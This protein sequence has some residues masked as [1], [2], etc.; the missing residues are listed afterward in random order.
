MKPTFTLFTALLLGP[1]AALD[2]A[3]LR[4]PSIFS[5]HMVLQCSKAVPV[6]GWGDAGE[7][8]VVEF[9]G[10]TKSTTA[11]A[12]G[13]WTVNLDAL[14]A[15]A[16]SREMVVRSPNRSHSVKIADV[17]VGEVWVGGGQS[18]MEFDM[19]AIPGVAAE[20][21]APTNPTLR[22]FHVLKNPSSRNPAD[23]VQG[24]WTFARPGTTEDFIAAGYYFAKQ[25]QRELKTPVGLI[26]VC[27]GGSKVEPWIS[28]DSLARVPELATAAKN[29][30]A[31]SERN[32]SA[33]LEWLK[34]TKREDRPAADVESFT[35]GPA[36]KENGWVTVR[37]N[38][39]SSDPTLPRLGAF[40]FRK[41]VALTARQTGAV[42]MLQF[43]PSAQF[44]QVYWNGTLIGA[45]DVDS[46]TGLT[47]VRHYLI[48]PALLKEGVNHLAVRIFAP[49]EQPGF[50][51]PPSVGS[52]KIPD[53][54]MAKAEYALP[55]LEPAAKQAVPPLTGQHV[56]PARLFHGMVHPILPY[57]IRGVLWYQGE[58]NTGNASLY[59]TTFPL[60]IRDWR[61]HWKQGDFP[62]YFCQLANYRPKTEQPGE[63]IWADL[64][65]AQAKTLSVP[66]TGMAVL[67]DT[68]ESEDIHP[69]SKQVAGE[70]L[71]RIALA[72]TYGLDVS[73]S[74][75]VYA[76]MRVESSAIRLFF[77]HLGGGLVAKELPATYDV[78]CKAGKTAPLARNSPHSQLE[79]FAIC[80]T[81][82][83][84]IWADARID[85][86]TVLVSSGR[87]ATP[88]A[89]RYGWSDN[90]T[91]NLYNAADLPASPFRT[92]DFPTAAA[93]PRPPLMPTATAT[94]ATISKP[95][96]LF[97]LADD[98]G[99]G[100]LRCHGNAKLATPSLDRLRTQSVELEHFHVS[101]IC[102]P[103][104]S[105]LLTGRHHARL[106]V[107][108]TS[109]SLEVMHGD[110]TTLAEA[111][112][113]AG[114]VAGCFGKWHN[115]SNHPSTARGQGFDEFFGFSGGFFPNYF[116]AQLEH[117]GVSTPTRGFITDVLA[118]AAMSF[119]DQNRARPFFCYVPFNACHSP[120]QAPQDLFEKYR[121]LG[122]EPKDAAVY[123]MIEN[124]DRN[125]GRL[126]QKLDQTGL[127]ANTIVLFTTDNGPNTAR[128][129][130]GMRGGKGSVFEGG[131]RVPC[132]IR[133]PDKLKSG[134]RVP[135]ITQHVDILPTLL[136]LAAVPLPKRQPLDGVS[137]VPLLK[138]N[139]SSWPQRT[140]FD[141]T[142]R[143][144]KD[145]TPIP[146]YPGTARTETHRWVHDG[147]QPMLFDLRNDPGEKTNLATQHPALAAEME[148]S[149]L[150]WFREVTAPSG[151]R[152]ARFPITLGEGTD[153]LVPNAARIGGAKL[154]GKGWDYDWATFPTPAAAMCWHL[155]VPVAGRY[156]VSVLHTA[157]N[158]GGEVRVTI[159]DTAARSTVTSVYDPPE[160]PRRDLI[161]RWEVPDKVFKPL[162]IGAIIIPAGSHDLQ[163]TAA[164][165]IEIQAVRLKRL[166]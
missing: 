69:Q 3:E 86:E 57:A 64:R 65:E 136:E 119:I 79:G 91:C 112:K 55:P 85:G 50:S 159:G 162:G 54:W 149:Y 32:K 128:Y 25:V 63:S 17:I 66:N 129:N 113:P 108:N 14:D 133:W 37:D 96:I 45:R 15:S 88:V 120:M 46:F 16:D 38:G 76:S 150:A 68:G 124:L 70:R 11:N 131:L 148:K 141:L 22:Q 154:F 163:V 43:G 21:E 134:S 122:F 90:P 82:G 102:S 142:G 40:W 95:N 125:V 157:K 97:I 100:D 114:Y 31:L 135:E 92:D 93:S 8:V 99:W 49:A 9:A 151:G 123:A 42:Q 145:G 34:Q 28:P 152:V 105:S 33:Y 160:I 2:A 48:P 155:S 80:G 51:W 138:G 24:F 153:L 103:T 58:S 161:P 164:P 115:G 156:A 4:L 20:I 127:S 13:R 121:T 117:N 107:I 41:K 137:L 116:D 72:K 147:K 44:D 146:E 35:I 74:G 132:F 110:E 29:M 139:T 6:W 130:G 109:D 60:L 30:D 87:V 36:S 26:K 61:Q 94:A 83:K 56:L 23:D 1:L 126:L 140:L 78:M 111:L 158:T 144:G 5:D 118:D 98:M 7:Q 12:D 18:N 27:W 19:K 77:D 71:A 89:V 39:P 166:N 165:G 62:F 52:T 101:P 10:Q 143:G 81:D 106:H 73:H 104:R 75:P 67:I 84:W 59:R 47:S 53:G